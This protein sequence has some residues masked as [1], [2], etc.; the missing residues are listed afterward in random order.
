MK[1]LHIIYALI[2]PIAWGINVVAMKVS[3]TEFPALFSNL[4]RFGLAAI[5]L[6]PFLKKITFNKYLFYTVFYYST[7]I[8]LATL[9][10]RGDASAALTILLFQLNVPITALLSS[11]IFK[12]KLDARKL[13]GIF[14]SFV[15]I[16]V[17]FFKPHM[18]YDYESIF[19]VLLSAC[20]WAMFNINLKQINDPNKMSLLGWVLLISVPYLFVTC[21]YFDHF[22]YDIAIHASLFAWGGIILS[23][24]FSTIVGFG[25]WSYLVQRYP[26]SIIAPFNL[27]APISGALFSFVVFGEKL[28]FAF[29]VGTIITLIGVITVV[30]GRKKSGSKTAT[31]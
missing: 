14:I 15:G 25:L 5:I 31:K 6:I 17:I 18:K 16:G 9:S 8:S 27:L 1:F 24:I 22:D 4:I 12:D 23:A 11:L 10:V 19:L 21:I 26:L 7:G 13:L 29:A 30:I 28:N 2:V 20:F 3:V